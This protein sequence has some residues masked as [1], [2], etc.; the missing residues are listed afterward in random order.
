MHDRAAFHFLTT[1]NEIE[2]YVA[3]TKNSITASGVLVIGT[4]SEDG[5]KKCSGI[6]IKQ[7]NESTI[8]KR[9]KKYFGKIK[10]ITV[11]H[12]TFQHFAE[13]YLLQF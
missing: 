13:L 12:L 6:E 11:D 3:T 7:Y 4:F 8:T 10:C 2:N 1:E 5:P 9:L